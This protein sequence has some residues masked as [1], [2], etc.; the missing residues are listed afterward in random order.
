MFA[1]TS[2]VFAILT[3]VCI[4]AISLSNIIGIAYVNKKANL[5]TLVGLATIFEAIGM[6]SM[7]RYTLRTTVT[8]TIPIASIVNL[9]LGFIVLGT[10][11]MCSAL[12]LVNVL[13][14]ALP[15]S[16]TQ[17]VIS[18][19]TG[20][21]I[22][23]FS[24]ID[25]KLTWFIEELILWIIAPIL[26]MGLAALIKYLMEKHIL[27]HPDCRKRILVMTPYYMTLTFYLML[28]VPLTK[29]FIYAVNIKGSSVLTIWYTIIMLFFPLF[30]MVIFRFL[31]LRRARSVENVKLKRKTDKD[32]QNKIRD[33][34]GAL[35]K[36]P[37]NDYLKYS[38]SSSR[39]PSW[40][41]GSE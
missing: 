30:F 25:A 24:A 11:Q 41:L 18:G 15:M 6:L 5:T 4:G 10:T 9:R 2:F 36:S 35:P 34:T 12:I 16:T 26:G 20:V 23:F 38:M 8:Q 28:G 7:S 39:R 32:S 1:Y 21:S 29:N 40:I 31:L 37:I 19:L 33:A 3:G 17:V 13:I 14:F 22:I 27:N